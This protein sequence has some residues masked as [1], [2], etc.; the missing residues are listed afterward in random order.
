MS[1]QTKSKLY[2]LIIGILLVTNI[3][4][5]FFFLKGRGHDRGKQ[6]P[7]TDR[8]MMMM[9]FLQKE[10]GFDSLQIQQYDSLSN[11]F[12]EKNKADMD[13]LK[14]N[15]EEQMKA[16]GSKGFSEQAIDSVVN[17]SAEN[18]KLLELHLLNHFASIRKLC[19]TDQLVKFDSSFYK[20]WSKKKKPEEKK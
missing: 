4:M 2:L 14:A 8:R 10:V 5:L 1:T 18:Q 3:G 6:P 7:R 15:K 19:N 11:R 17:R 9:N 16:L 12:K 13:T 20:I